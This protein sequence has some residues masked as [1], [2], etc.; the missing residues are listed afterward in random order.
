MAHEPPRGGGPFLPRPGAD[1]P[2]FWIG[3][4]EP[5]RLRW[6]SPTLVGSLG[7]APGAWREPGFLRDLV[8][9]G[10]LSRLSEAWR[11]V[12][13]TR[14][15]RTLDI[16]ARSAEG[17]TIPLSIEL[18]A[19][20][21]VDGV[22][23]VLG[24]V[25]PGAGVPSRVPRTWAEAHPGAVASSLDELIDSIDGIV[26]EATMDFQ[27]TF[28]SKQA[29]R[30]LGYP[31]SNWFEEPGFWASHLHPEDREWATTYCVDAAERCLPHEFEYRMI[32]A[33]GRSV[34][35]RDIVT[36]A[37]E[38]GRASRLRGIMVDVTTQH[39][40]QEGLEHTVS[41]LQATLD[42]TTDGVLVVDLE[43]HITTYN[44][45]FQQLWGLTDTQLGP[46]RDRYTLEAVHSQVED[47]DGF[48]LRVGELYA[49]PE[50]EELGTMRLKDGR[51]IER[52]SIPQ[53]RRGLITGR[54]WSFRDVTQRV[55]AEQERERL[56][57]EAQEAIQ[58]R[59]DFLSVASHELKTPL[60]PL[61]LHLQVL[62]H[63]LESG[64]SITPARLDK[65]LGQVRRLT[66]L[67]NDLLDASCVGEC[68]LELQLRP[69][70]LRE[71]LRE[72]VADFRT[73]SSLHTFTLDEPDQELRSLGDRGRLQQVMTNL[74]E[75]AVKYS[76][77]GG[78][79]H[80]ALG[81]DGTYAQLSV[82]DE[83]IG[84]PRDELPHLF[85]RFYRARNSPA[86]GFGGLGL[87]LYLSRDIIERHGGHMWVEN[88]LGRGSTFHVSLPVMAA[89]GRHEAHAPPA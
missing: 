39:R 64:L 65:A 63:M 81:T 86:S 37:A 52:Y 67:V 88:E 47:P 15:P 48:L 13:N 72:V 45:R 20:D 57:R 17:H 46:L 27:F 43:G 19:L 24:V 71:V 84:I 66:V 23:E 58:V 83:G 25:K 14:A 85:E 9:P 76:P 42:S 11:E 8:H 55:R 77:L 80:V 60:T 36:V 70:P 78:A 87:G 82:R 79:V 16:R 5:T 53:R 22:P 29:E 28:V 21:G 33:D 61:R 50:R 56:L 2:L 10:D 30:L 89:A 68:R 38:H 34:W 44:R 40:T 18:S 35:L 74:L 1:P 32:A 73:T 75:N 12:T 62:R 41:V 51:I 59:D 3:A 7:H 49:A 26:W 69:V 31:L 54:V 6:V 4:G